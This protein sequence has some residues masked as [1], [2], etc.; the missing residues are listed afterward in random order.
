REYD[1]ET[2]LRAVLLLD[3]SGSMAYGGKSGGKF[4]YAA[5]M[6]ASLAYLMLGQTE[7]VGLATFSS[8][9]EN[10]IPPRPGTPQLSRIIDTLERCAPK[11]ESALAGLLHTVADRLD[12]RALVIV[13]SDCFVP[14]GPVREG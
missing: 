11:G 12:R 4:D 13:L 1:E 10:W 9:M 5:R 2:N 6:A 8:R 3:C 14:V 7:S